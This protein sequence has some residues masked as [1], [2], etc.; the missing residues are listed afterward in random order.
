MTYWI[1][2]ASVTRMMSFALPFPV[3]VAL[4]GVFVV[5]PLV[6]FF[7]AQ[8]PSALP[9]ATRRR[10]ANLPLSSSLIGSA[11]WIAGFVFT[12]IAIGVRGLE[13]QMDHLAFIGL[14][15]FTQAGVIFVPSY[16]GAE[17]LVRRF[18]MPALYPGDELIRESGR[19]FTPRLRAR[20]LILHFSTVILPAF[21]IFALLLKLN[22]GGNN[23]FGRD[24][25]Y[26]IFLLAVC[27]AGVTLLIALQ[28]AAARSANLLSLNTTRPRVA[29][30]QETSP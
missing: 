28:K 2:E 3:V 14:Q 19:I 20:I 15:L 5:P 1:A 11:G 18:L 24:L 27:I 29:P 17:Y 23:V 8:D 30:L 16:Y 6:R 9:A 12:L 25:T 22:D 4:F 13:L 7:R 21:L 26:E 10:L